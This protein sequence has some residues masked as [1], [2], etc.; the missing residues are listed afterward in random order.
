MKRD[1]YVPTDLAEAHATAA[2]GDAWTLVFVRK[3][4]S[5]STIGTP[6]S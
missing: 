1:D 6:Y 2:E 3:I 5:V 4:R